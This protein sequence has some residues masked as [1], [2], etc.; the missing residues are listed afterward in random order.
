MIY[1]GDFHK[2][3]AKENIVMSKKKK[4]WAEDGFE[5]WVS[6]LFTLQICYFFKFALLRLLK[7][8]EL[9]VYAPAKIKQLINYIYKY[10]FKN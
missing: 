7:N 10:N 1:Y 6:E 5:S 2:K 4:A 9:L 8:S 3:S